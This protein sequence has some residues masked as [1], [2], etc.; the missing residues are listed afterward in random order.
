MGSC[1]VVESLSNYWS[2]VE[3]HFRFLK[4]TLKIFPRNKIEESLDKK[5][6]RQ[7]FDPLMLK[8]S[9]EFLRLS[10]INLLCY[11]FLA[12]GNYL[13]WAKVTRYYSYFYIVNSLLRLKGFAVVNLNFSDESFLRLRIDKVKNENKY[14][15][16]RCRSS[17]HQIIAKRFSE[18]F[19]DLASEEMGKFTIRERVDWNYDLFFASQTTDKYSLEQAEDRCKHNFLDPNFESASSYEAAEY[20]NDLMANFG[21]EE[22]GTGDYIRFTIER[23]SE[24]GKESKH[25][26]WY[27]EFFESL[28]YD[29]EVL[30]SKQDMKDEIRKW[31]STALKKNTLILNNSPLQ[32]MPLCSKNKISEL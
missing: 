18:L 1:E 17:P 14:R 8:D 19:P 30:Q 28:F 7:F 3:P 5:L 21:Y 15:M 32:H 16:L 11:K 24:I 20:K 29:I 22:A 6:D 4:E 26:N 31:I 10:I 27:K 23:F 2:N 13:A 25:K 12:C 9:S